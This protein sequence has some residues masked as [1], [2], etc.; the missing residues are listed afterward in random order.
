MKNQKRRGR[1]SLNKVRLY[2]Q[3]EKSTMDVLVRR[4]GGSTRGLGVAIENA[5]E[6]SI[7]FRK[8]S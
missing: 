8:E 5:V 3:V 4:A 6:D 7:Q 1:P 2:T